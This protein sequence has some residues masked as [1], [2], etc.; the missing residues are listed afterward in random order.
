VPQVAEGLG[1]VSGSGRG[2]G[3]IVCGANEA[4]GIGF[5]RAAGGQEG[6]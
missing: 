2:L 1:T 3:G 4:A 5:D 6:L